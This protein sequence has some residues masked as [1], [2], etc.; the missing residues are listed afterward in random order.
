[1]L[2]QFDHF[3]QR[4]IRARARESQAVRRELLAIS[5]VEFV[6]MPMPLRDFRLAIARRGNAARL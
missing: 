5:I 1:M 4:V 2:R 6:A 3:Y